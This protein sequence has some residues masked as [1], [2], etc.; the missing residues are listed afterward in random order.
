MEI[1]YTF[2]SSIHLYGL[3]NSVEKPCAKGTVV[4]LNACYAETRIHEQIAD[5][6]IHFNREPPQLT[7]SFYHF[8]K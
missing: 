7:L 8:L 4:V 3:I 2:Q 5:C 1:E 6:I